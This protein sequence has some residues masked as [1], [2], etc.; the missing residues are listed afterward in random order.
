VNETSPD[1]D[2][3][4][5]AQDDDFS[6]GSFGESTWA[7]AN[8]THKPRL[9][10]AYTPDLT[11]WFDGFSSSSGTVDAM[12]GLGRISTT[13]NAGTFSAPGVVDLGTLAPAFQPATPGL[14]Y[15]QVE[16][17]PGAT[18]RPADA[19]SPFTGGGTIDCDP[20]LIPPGP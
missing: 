15:G 9:A 17:C 20:S 8:G 10:A 3:L 11:A 2:P 13:F 5:D 6:Q 18:E 12:G 19:S 16:R 1:C 14:T 7:L 4:E